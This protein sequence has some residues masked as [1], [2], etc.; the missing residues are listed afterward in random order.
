MKQID[1]AFAAGGGA[2]G[3][4]HDAAP[5]GVGSRIQILEPVLRERLE[6]SIRELDAIEIGDTTLGE[7]AEH[8]ALAVGHP[9]GREYGDQP[10]ELISS[11]H[12]ASLQVPYDQRVA[13]TIARGEQ[14]EPLP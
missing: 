3:R 13:V 2:V 6:L 7:T 12:L 9:H 5:V 11:R 1:C 4:K 8:D 10:V 14:K